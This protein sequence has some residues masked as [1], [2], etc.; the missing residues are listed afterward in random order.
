MKPTLYFFLSNITECMYLSLFQPHFLPSF[1]EIVKC[2]KLTIEVKFG[3][4]LGLINAHANTKYLTEY[5]INV[6]IIFYVP[7]KLPIHYLDR[8]KKWKWKCFV[9]S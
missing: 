7:H 8:F 2:S 5:K 6:R 4:N 3:W 1:E 9:L